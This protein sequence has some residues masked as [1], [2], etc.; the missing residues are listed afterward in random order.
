MV[1]WWLCIYDSNTL[2]CAPIWPSWSEGNRKRNN[3]FCWIFKYRWRYCCCITSDAPSTKCR[4]PHS[5][6][7]VYMCIVYTYFG[8]VHGISFTQNFLFLFS[9]LWS[10]V[11]L[12][13]PRFMARTSA[14][15]ILWVYLIES[16]LA[17]PISTL[18]QCII[19]NFGWA[20]G[21]NTKYRR[22]EKRCYIK[23]HLCIYT[24]FAYSMF[25]AIYIWLNVFEIRFSQFSDLFHSIKYKQVYAWV[26]TGHKWLWKE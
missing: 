3:F 9:F 17:W 20:K 25:S 5:T 13:A 11:T 21:K 15:I 10:C 24:F 4:H 22:K 19:W 6:L 7:H 18:F 23:T 8:Y 26:V 16:F 12:I 1:H 14:E 2:F